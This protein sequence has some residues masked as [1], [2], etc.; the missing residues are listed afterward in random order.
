MHR[1]SPCRCCSAKRHVAAWVG[2]MH[3]N[4]HSKHAECDVADTCHRHM[5]RDK[6]TY[7]ATHTHTPENVYECMLCIVGVYVY[8]WVFMSVYIYMFKYTNM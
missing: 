1:P 3:T 5:I 8:P 4:S 2:I 7:I 6:H